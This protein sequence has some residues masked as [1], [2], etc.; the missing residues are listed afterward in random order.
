L[1]PDAPK[2]G[3]PT[4]G[5]S[6]S[7]RH[8]TPLFSHLIIFQQHGV[9]FGHGILNKGGAKKRE[10]RPL[11][12]I[13]IM[14]AAERVKTQKKAERKAA[15]VRE[16]PTFPGPTRSPDRHNPHKKKII[17]SIDQFSDPRRVFTH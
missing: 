10:K 13:E 11:T 4:L 17:S 1:H 2:V 6:L 8:L 5:S 14:A 16:P 7:D 12:Q 9:E 15:K 3:R